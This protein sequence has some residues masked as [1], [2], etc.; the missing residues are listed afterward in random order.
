[1]GQLAIS[2]ITNH[3]QYF[4]GLATGWAF[5]HIPAAVLLAFHLAMKIPWLRA[6]VVANPAQA[7]AIIDAI[8]TELDKDIDD[9]AKAAAPLPPT[10]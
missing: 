4:L 3:Q 9:E 7:K 10:P 6:Q 5:A 8:H 2:F 1:M